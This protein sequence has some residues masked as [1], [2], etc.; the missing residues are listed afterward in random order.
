MRDALKSLFWLLLFCAL[1][2]CVAAVPQ[3]PQLPPETLGA[4]QI[5]VLFSGRTA[6]ADAA[7]GSGQELVIYFAPNGKLRQTRQGWQEEGTWNARWDGRLC[8]DLKTAKPDCRII[9]AAG[10]EYRQYAVKKDGNHRHELTYVEFRAGD[11][12]SRM[13]KEPLLPLGTLDR[14]QLKKLFSDRT[15]ESVTAT[16]GRVSRT[17]YAPDGSVEQLQSGKRRYG[18]W[19]VSKNARICLQMDERQEK[20][21]IIVQ[22]DGEFKKYI[23]KKNGR[24]QHSISY[25]KFTPGNRL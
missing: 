12:L 2:G 11:Q 1:P 24:H 9:V 25:R 21:R 18:K 22:E 23:V 14:K 19:R 20:C 17:Y 6:A 7:D 4:E 8:V 15:V 16:K 3:G 13:S 10:K 5:R